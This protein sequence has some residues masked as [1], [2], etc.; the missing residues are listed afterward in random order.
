MITAD[1]PAALA[2]FAL[3]ANVTDDPSPLP[4]LI[5]A[6]LPLTDIGKSAL[7][8]PKAQSTNVPVAVPNA[9]PVSAA[10]ASCAPASGRTK[11]RVPVPTRRVESTSTPGAEIATC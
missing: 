11:A 2:F 8:A 5:T 7:V 3:V 10:E 4:R 6:I 1:A 9:E